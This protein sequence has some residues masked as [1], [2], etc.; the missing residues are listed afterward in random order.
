MTDRSDGPLRTTERTLAIVQY[1][2]NEGPARLSEIA[3]DLD[4]AKS[5]VHRHLDTLHDHRYVSREGQ[6]YQIGLR[7]T[8]LG[9]AARTRHGG[10]H[11]VGSEVREIASE[12]GERAQFLAEDHGLGVYL[13]VERG[14]RAIRMDMEPGRQIHLHCSASGKAILANYSRERVDEIVDQ[15]GLPR[16]TRETITDREALFE[17][18]GDVRERGVAFN[19]EEHVRG[20]TAVAVPVKSEDDVIGAISVAAPTDRMQNER[21]EETIPDLLLG[22]ANALELELVY[23][24]EDNVNTLLVE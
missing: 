4:V 19:H 23:S 3:A 24:T 22:S 12:T 16:Q 17:E 9:Q 14:E 10:F 5:T 11:R 20:L 21:I 8:R 1:L 6:R 15:W 2:Q 7:F 18:L 13:Y